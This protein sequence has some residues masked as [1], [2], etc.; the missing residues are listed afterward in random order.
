MR[1]KDECIR[2]SREW[3]GI[4]AQ[5]QKRILI[6]YGE[7]EKALM[8]YLESN[9]KVTLDEFSKECKIPRRVASRVLVNLTAAGVLRI[10]PGIGSEDQFS[11]V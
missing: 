6:R 2:A 10:K 3:A 5:A 11:M 9:S 4:M 7:Q 1:V 8:N